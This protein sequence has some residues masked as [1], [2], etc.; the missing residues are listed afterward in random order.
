MKTVFIII[1]IITITVLAVFFVLGK[2][3]QKDQPPILSD[4]KLTKCSSKPNCV[5]SEYP[6]DDKRFIEPITENTENVTISK[7]ESIILEMGGTTVSKTDNYI[8]STF[9]SSFF[10]FVDDFEIRID[11]TSGDILFRSGSR[12]GYSDRGVN[13]KRVELFKQIYQK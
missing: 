4:G 6:S 13:K 5:C 7:L 8:S 1:L 11:E 9:T 12:V 10:G 2:Q 3:S